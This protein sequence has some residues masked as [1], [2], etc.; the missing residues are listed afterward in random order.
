M[1]K[2]CFEKEYDKFNSSDEFDVFLEEFNSKIAKT[3][4]FVS[5]EK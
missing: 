1:C 5:T 4:Q 3:F 2:N